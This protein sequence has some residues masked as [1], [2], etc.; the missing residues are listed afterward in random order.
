[1][2]DDFQ[3]ASRFVVDFA[4]APA[5]FKTRQELCSDV[6]HIQFECRA[7]AFERLSYLNRGAVSKRILIAPQ[8]QEPL[9]GLAPFS[10]ICTSS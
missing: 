3:R 10:Y 6:N 1:M 4:G 9:Y 7:A 5:F 8:G 2:L